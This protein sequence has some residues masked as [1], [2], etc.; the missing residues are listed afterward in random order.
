MRRSESQYEKARADRVSAIARM[1]TPS[2]GGAAFVVAESNPQQ[3][4]GSPETY[5]DQQRP[6][7]EDLSRP[8]RSHDQVN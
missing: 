2:G 3:A 6:G 4:I 7:Q 5:R 1:R 8:R